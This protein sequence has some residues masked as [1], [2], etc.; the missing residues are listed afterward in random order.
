MART[1]VLYAGQ[2]GHTRDILDQILET[3]KDTV[4]VEDLCR[5]VPARFG[6]Y[7]RVALGGSIR[8]KK[9]HPAVA[10][11]AEEHK[12]TL[13]AKPLALFITGLDKELMQ[14]QL[15]AAFS[16]TLLE[17]STVA[18]W[19]GGEL[20]LRRLNPFIRFVMRRMTGNPSER[21]W[22]NSKGIIELQ[23]FVHGRSD[24]SR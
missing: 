6:V 20:D 16:E 14:E 10:R 19:L 3:D 2:H 11:F 12:H 15:A 1:I 21:S 13:L 8:S 18:V 5:F 4:T 23:E 22:R 17:H 9:I 24:H 7:D